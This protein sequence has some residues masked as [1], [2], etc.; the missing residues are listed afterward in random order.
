L[1]LVL[2][3]AADTRRPYSIALRDWSGGATLWSRGQLAATRSGGEAMVV[4]HLAGD[5]LARGSYELV[6]TVTD[7]NG[8]A[9]EVAAYE[10]TIG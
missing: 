4:A 5:V 3:A 2:P 1:R 10:L 8:H 6:L 7:A 9:A